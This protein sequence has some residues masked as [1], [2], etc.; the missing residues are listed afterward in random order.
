MPKKGIGAQSAEV[1]LNNKWGRAETMLCVLESEGLSADHLQ[2][3]QAS[4][5]CI[6]KLLMSGLGR[7]I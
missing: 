7:Q 3:K 2:F 5:L 4:Q 1:V 6:D